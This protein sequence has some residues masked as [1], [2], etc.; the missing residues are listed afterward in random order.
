[1][2]NC[3]TEHK[4]AAVRV[5]PADLIA[6]AAA[7]NLRFDFNCKKQDQPKSNVIDTDVGNFLHPL[8][9]TLDKFP[10]TGS[11]LPTVL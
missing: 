7:A 4:K 2:D 6:L 5:R 3:G 10:V 9:L 11:G 1:M 8:A